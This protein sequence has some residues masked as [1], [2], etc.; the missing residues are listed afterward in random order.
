MCGE[1]FMEWV[2]MAE[3]LHVS[4]TSPSTVS[5]VGWSG[6]KHDAGLQKRVLWSDESNFLFGSLMGC[7]CLTDAGRTLPA[8]LHCTNSKVWW[9]R[10]NGM[11]LFMPL[12]SSKQSEILMIQLSKTF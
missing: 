7:V 9:R 10:N 12:T 2:P 1:N 5:T 6:V 3:Q 11:T 8:W 4:I